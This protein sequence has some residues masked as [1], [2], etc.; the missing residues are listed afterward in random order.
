MSPRLLRL[1]VALALLLQIVLTVDTAGAQ[2]ISADEIPEELIVGLS[3]Q[4]HTEASDVHTRAGGKYL[5]GLGSQAV[6]LVGVTRAESANIKAKYKRD[7]RVR[8]V[9]TN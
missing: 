6:H 2:T 1:C 3:S 9:E 5:K 4:G 8:F 7:P